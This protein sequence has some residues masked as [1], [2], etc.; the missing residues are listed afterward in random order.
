MCLWVI[1][2]RNIDYND[3]STIVSLV[4]EYIT[5][6]LDINFIEYY[7]SGDKDGI[8]ISEIKKEDFDRNLIIRF[9]YV[10]GIVYEFKKI[11]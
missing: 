3:Y 4:N 1:E 6:K 11:F 8:E 7:I 5:P 2:A 10:M 9:S